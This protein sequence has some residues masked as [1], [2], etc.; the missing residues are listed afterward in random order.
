MQS[1][2]EG[3]FFKRLDNALQEIGLQSQQY[4][5]GCICWKTV[6]IKH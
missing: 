2:S 3:T 1:N 4:I 6:F 5:G